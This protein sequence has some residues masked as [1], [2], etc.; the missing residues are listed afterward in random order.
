MQ[1]VRLR[2]LAQAG[3]TGND[4]GL[5]TQ[6]MGKVASPPEF[7]LCGLRWAGVCHREPRSEHG[8]TGA[9]EH[10]TVGELL[11]E[12]VRWPGER[13][14]ACRARREDCNGAVSQCKVNVK[15]A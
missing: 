14:Q 8:S 3:R 1:S 6:A 11:T 4:T 7:K 10:G 2:N 9:R 15:A 13:E 12:R 5:L